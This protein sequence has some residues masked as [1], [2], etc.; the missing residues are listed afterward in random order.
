M[1]E[2]NANSLA[3]VKMSWILIDSFVDMQFINVKKPLKKTDK[4]K[5]IK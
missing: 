1:I 2:I 4:R 5:V 3:A